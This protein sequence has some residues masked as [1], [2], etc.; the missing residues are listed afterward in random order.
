MI[1][2][3]L[4]RHGH[5]CMYNHRTLARPDGH[6]LVPRPKH[7]DMNKAQVEPAGRPKYERNQWLPYYSVKK[8]HRLLFITE[9]DALC[10]LAEVALSIVVPFVCISM[11]VHAREEG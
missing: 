9:V 11:A 6:V 8:V 2:S 7:G 5:V 10:C 4:T 3:R 1:C